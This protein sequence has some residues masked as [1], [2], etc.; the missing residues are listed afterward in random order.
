[1]GFLG[2]KIALFVAPV[3]W[4]MRAARG[5][6]PRSSAD[7]DA[8][9]GDARGAGI[10]G[11][12][13]GA[14]ASTR[15]RNGRRLRGPVV[16]P[17]GMALRTRRPTRLAMACR[18]PDF[19]QQ[20]FDQQR[21]HP[22]RLPRRPLAE[23]LG[24]RQLARP[25]PPRTRRTTSSTASAT[26]LRRNHVHDWFRRGDHLFGRGASTASPPW[27]ADA[28]MESTGSPSASVATALSAVSA[29]ISS[30]VSAGS[31][32]VS[33]VTG[34]VAAFG[35]SGTVSRG[36]DAARSGSRARAGSRQSS[37]PNSRRAKSSQR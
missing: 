26:R 31:V 20:R 27:S 36:L 18:P 17:R 37:R 34:S 15:R 14:P 7:D 4:T 9:A 19:D 2:R 21:V 16:A 10:S 1:M 24:V 13:G 33:G 6:G 12:V 35:S 32:G 3:V 28:A 22:A 11:A 30:D 23:H 5:R 29:T 8:A 25:R